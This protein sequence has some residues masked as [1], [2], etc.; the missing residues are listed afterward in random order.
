MFSAFSS[1]QK[2]AAKVCFLIEG[3]LPCLLFSPLMLIHNFCF[4]LNY[5]PEIWLIIFKRKNLSCM[6]F[7]FFFWE[8]KINF[9]HWCLNRNCPVVRTCNCFAVYQY[10]ICLIFCL[11]WK[12]DH[13]VGRDFGGKKKIG[14]QEFEVEKAACLNKYLR[15]SW[16]IV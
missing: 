2:Y 14:N 8:I 3:K 12:M 5:F 9:M 16:V 7:F 1:V 11:N 15:R 6:F 10:L 13:G 4:F